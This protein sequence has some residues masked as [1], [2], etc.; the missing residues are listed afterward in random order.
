[1]VTVI[2]LPDADATG[3]KHPIRVYNN[4]GTVSEVA[5]TDEAALMFGEGSS[6]W[7]WACRYFG[8][9]PPKPLTAEQIAARLKAETCLATYQHN[10]AIWNIGT[11]FAAVGECIALVEAHAQA[12]YEVSVADAE[13]LTLRIC[14]SLAFRS[15]AL[16]FERSPELIPFG[17]AVHADC[18]RGDG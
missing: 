14:R 12:L 16:L 5:S 7:V 8:P 18:G 11:A 1:V 17:E 15:L 3:A 10:V 6:M 9:P 4:D 2:T 13:V